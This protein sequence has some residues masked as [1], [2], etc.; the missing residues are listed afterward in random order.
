[1]SRNR[2]IVVAALS[3]LAGCSTPPP[4]PRVPVPRSPA[5]G[6]VKT[7][8]PLRPLREQTAGEA[9]PPP[10]FNDVALVTQAP[11]EQAMYLDAYAKV[12]KPRIA[13]FVNRT[14][15]GQ[16]IPVADRKLLSAEERRI[17]TRGN[18]EIDSRRSSDT[19]GPGRDRSTDASASLKSSGPASVTD[20][21]ERYLGPGE[22]DE[23]QA[24]NID[25]G[26][27]E[28]ALTDAL[29]ANGRVT[30]VSPSMARQRLTDEEVK[31]LQEGRPQVLREI[32]EKLDADVL[33]QVQARPTKQTSSG[34]GVRVLV[35]AINTKGGESVA[36]S[37]V[38][39]DP[40]LDKPTINDY[41]RFL[42]RK[43]MYELSG[44]WNAMGSE[45]AVRTPLPTTT[46]R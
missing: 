46:P 14:F 31:E 12:G 27:I 5:D 2:W 9:I 24:K 36:R 11:P 38:D 22:Y 19:Y 29:A 32:A 23:A 7:Y 18:V 21:F 26:A 1:M 44:S 42:A 34:L 33:I 4:P 10:T 25:Y 13:V 41:T 35:E 43:V 15:E 45:P 20:T 3:A 8:E 37:Y 40:P 28:L 39:I 16:I 6:A 30:L 17:E